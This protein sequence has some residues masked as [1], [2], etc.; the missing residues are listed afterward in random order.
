MM[1]VIATA[2][3]LILAAGSV[4]SGLYQANGQEPPDTVAIGHGHKARAINALVRGDYASAIQDGRAAIWERPFDQS[5]ISAVGTAYLATGHAQESGGY[6]RAS[7]AL[8][9]RDYLTQRFW[10]TQSL[11]AHSFAPGAQWLDAAMRTSRINNLVQAGLPVL[12]STDQGRAALVERIKQNPVWLDTWMEQAY[13]LDDVDLDDRLAVLDQI[14]RAGVVPSKT[15]I[16]N[17]AN[18]LYYQQRYRASLDLWEA[19]ATPGS[20]VDSGLW[21]SDFSHQPDEDVPASPFQWNLIQEGAAQPTVENDNGHWHLS[22]TS[23]S[24]IAQRVARQT[25]ILPAGPLKVTWQATAAGDGSPL[26]YPR[27]GCYNGPALKPVADG[28][29]GTTHWIAIIVPQQGCPAQAV[30]IWFDPS[31]S[32]ATTASLDFVQFQPVILR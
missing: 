3:A 28:H 32:G 26:L 17:A 21:E 22:V 13:T 12:E 25:T 15:A 9:W 5:S 27:I 14:K 19:A 16:A 11:E 31:F 8:G 10:I 7:A 2:G 30:T 24:H 1:R 6:F 29:D 4:A 23:D 20:I 18:A